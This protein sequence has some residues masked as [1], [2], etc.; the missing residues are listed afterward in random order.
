MLAT[1]VISEIDAQG[2]PVEAGGDKLDFEISGS[3]DS[4]QDDLTATSPLL[5]PH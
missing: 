1:D 5:C 4:P 2:I 3:S